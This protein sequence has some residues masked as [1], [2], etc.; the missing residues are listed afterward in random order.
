MDLY[1]PVQ[2]FNVSAWKSK[3]SENKNIFLR[4]YNATPIEGFQGFCNFVFRKN[5][6]VPRPHNVLIPSLI[7]GLNL[8]FKTIYVAGA[9]HS[10]LSEISVDDDNR[11]LM[12]Q[13]HFYDQNISKAETVKQRDFSEAHIHN[14]LYH[15]YVAF[16]SYFVIK[17]YAQS[18]DK[19]IFNITPKSFIDAFDRKSI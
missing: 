19:K 11:L 8:P 16:K 17:S 2:A 13:K 7:I 1:I 6:G 14:T 9:D 3:V 4:K 10:W 5:L 18:I 15:M 12:N